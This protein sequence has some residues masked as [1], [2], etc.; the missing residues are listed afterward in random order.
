MPKV[1]TTVTLDQDVLR[2]VKVRA[3]RLG[4]PVGEVIEQSLWRALGLDLL[5]RLWKRDELGETEAMQ[6]AVEGQHSTR[7]KPNR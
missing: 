3:A 5:E 2:W 7:R 4:R 1:R 6:L